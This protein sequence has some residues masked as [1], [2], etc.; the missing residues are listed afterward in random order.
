M[1]EQVGERVTW[2]VL[3]GFCL[4]VKGGDDHVVIGRGVV[5]MPDRF[6]LVRLE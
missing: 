3:S 6:Q 2:I 4:D 5:D 1:T